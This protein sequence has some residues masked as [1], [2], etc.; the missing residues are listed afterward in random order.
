MKHIQK[1]KSPFIYVE[2]FDF[3]SQTQDKVK[4]SVQNNFEEIVNLQDCG[5]DLTISRRRKFDGYFSYRGDFENSAN[6]VRRYSG[7]LNYNGVYR[8]EA[9]GFSKFDGAERY[10]GRKN[11]S[12][13]EVVTD[14]D[15][16]FKVIEIIDFEKIPIA[17]YDKLGYVIAGENVD[18][19]AEGKI[20]LA[21]DFKLPNMTE[22]ESGKLKNIFENWRKGNA[23]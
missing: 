21:K 12:V 7:G 10:G 13:Y 5:G 1:D 9:D 3:V 17:T 2:N 4:I 18:I 20:S 8:Q 14:L 11:Y 6:G 15:G 23:V 22:M 16:N 19:D